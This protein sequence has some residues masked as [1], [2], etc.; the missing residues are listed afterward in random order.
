MK[1]IT[2]TLAG[3][4]RIGCVAGDQIIDFATAAPELPREMIA[5]L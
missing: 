1:L 3:A 5:L 2:F 4:T